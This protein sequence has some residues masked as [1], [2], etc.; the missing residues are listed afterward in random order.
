MKWKSDFRL[1]PVVVRLFALGFYAASNAAY[2]QASQASQEQLELTASCATYIG[3]VVAPLTFEQ[4]L[5]GIKIVPPKG[6]FETS[7][8]YAD[9]VSASESAKE[10]I[11]STPINRESLK[12]DADNGKF[13]VTIYLF[14]G[15][16]RLKFRD[17]FWSKQDYKTDA[18]TFN[19]A[20]KYSSTRKLI[21]YYTGTNSFGTKSNIEKITYFEQAIFE[22]ETTYDKPLFYITNGNLGSNIGYISVPMDSAAEFK[23][24]V[25]AAF[26]II[27]KAPYVETG[28]Y[29]ESEPTF[30][31][32]YDVK[33]NATI[34]MADIRC[35][36][37]MDGARKVVAAFATR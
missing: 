36:L 1:I 24:K 3:T 6:E 12:Y 9:R 25:T 21:G 14:D 13:L 8:A 27:P 29:Q 19:L 20:L 11:I 15:K 18:G 37:I 28:S 32:P 16:T 26:V 2:A 35:A 10:I 22:N 23:A 33:V 17:F 34:L 31:D 30:A 5:A 7:L 4:A